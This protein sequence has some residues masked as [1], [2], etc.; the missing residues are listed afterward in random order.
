MDKELI[1]SKFPDLDP[2]QIEEAWD[3]AVAGMLENCEIHVPISVQEDGFQAGLTDVNSE[4]LSEWNRVLEIYF[5]DELEEEWESCNGE[6]DRGKSQSRDLLDFIAIEELSE[7][8]EEKVR[9]KRIKEEDRR[10]DLQERRE[11]SK[12]EEEI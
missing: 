7:E 6:C 8:Q 9:E 12:F 3:R 4:T 10:R 1:I 5:N 11:R 2:E